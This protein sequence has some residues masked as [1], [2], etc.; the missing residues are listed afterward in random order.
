MAVNTS[1]PRAAALRE[2]LLFLGAPKE[3]LDFVLV[4]FLPDLRQD[5]AEFR[6]W[7]ETVSPAGFAR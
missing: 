1:Y 3:D 4:G 6:S 2:S 7:L 5:L